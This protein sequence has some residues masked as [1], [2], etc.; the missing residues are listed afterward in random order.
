MKKSIFFA[1]LILIVTL[2]WL[3]SGQ[4]GKDNLKKDNKITNVDVSKNKNQIEEEFKNINS[5]K[6]E[7]K[8][9]ISKKIDQS[10]LIQGQTKYNKKIDV[11]SETTGNIT[12]LNF[13]RGDRVNQNSLLIN[14]SQDNRIQLINSA[15]KLIDLYEIE[16]SSAKKLVDKGLSSKSKLALASYNLADAKSKLKNI[17]IEFERTVINA[18]FDGI[19]TEKFVE[20]SDFVSPGDKLITIVNLN[21]III[22]AYLSEFDINKVKKNTLAIIENSNGIRKEGKITFISPSAETTTRTFEITI[23]V[24]NSDLTYKSG[25]TTS[26]IIKGSEEFQAHK[27]PPSILTLQDNGVVGVKALTKDNIVIFYPILKIKDTIDGM[28]VSGLPNEVNLII[29]GQE[30]VTNGQLIDLE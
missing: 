11:K 22:Q 23:E 5:I 12:K 13:K 9:F 6:V 30:Y 4:Y 29:S 8:S 3:L 15:K 17:Q 27:I 1:L 20:L 21:P 7:T 16:Y 25:V 14:I 24:D 26:I 18:P 2:G 10:I 28:W 19:I